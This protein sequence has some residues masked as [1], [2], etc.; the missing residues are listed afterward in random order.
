MVP[1]VCVMMEDS[2]KTATRDLDLVPFEAMI[3]FD[4]CSNLDTSSLASLPI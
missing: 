3:D 1:S 2:R 4:L